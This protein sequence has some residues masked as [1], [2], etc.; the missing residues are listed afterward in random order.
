M[1]NE[2]LRSLKERLL[3]RATIIQ[4]RLDQEQQNLENAY[5]SVFA[6]WLREKFEFFEFC[7]FACFFVTARGLTNYDFFVQQT[8]KRKGEQYAATDQEAYEKEVANANFKMDILTE[9]A[10]QHYKNSLE[11]FQQLD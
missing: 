10:S 7:A 4:N 2:A 5:V 1:K 9:R 8:L 6:V 3:T 11:K